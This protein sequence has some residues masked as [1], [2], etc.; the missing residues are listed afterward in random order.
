MYSTSV[1]P[2]FSTAKWRLQSW[3]D[4]SVSCSNNAAYRGRKA[5]QDSH[6]LECSHHWS[7]PRALPPP[8]IFSRSWAPSGHCQRHPLG[9]HD[10]SID[11]L[12]SSLLPVLDTCPHQRAWSRHP[13][14]DQPSAQSARPRLQLDE[15]SSR[16]RTYKVRSLYNFVDEAEFLLAL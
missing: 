2:Y 11:H 9:P 15:V 7:P 13:T 8:P 4:P 10:T 14:L 16:P 3:P 5:L 12:L 6:P 1:H